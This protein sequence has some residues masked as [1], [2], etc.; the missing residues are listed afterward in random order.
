MVGETHVGTGTGAIETLLVRG[1][2]P[3]LFRSDG[4]DGRRGAVTFGVA[5]STTISIFKGRPEVARWTVK[6]DAEERQKAKH[7]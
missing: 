6:N 5:S 3:N 7:D 2:S 1:F 4:A